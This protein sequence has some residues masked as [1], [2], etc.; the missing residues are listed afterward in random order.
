[1]ERIGYSVARKLDSQSDR[2]VEVEIPRPEEAW[3][4]VEVWLRD[5]AGAERRVRR[6]ERLAGERGP[7]RGV[8]VAPRRKCE[9]LV[10]SDNCSMTTRVLNPDDRGLVTFRWEAR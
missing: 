1:M 3:E 6:F 8:F 7:L 10:F 9:L 4:Y 5:H 2:A